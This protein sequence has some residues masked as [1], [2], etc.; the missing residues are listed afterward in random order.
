MEKNML[1][2]KVNTFLEVCKQLNFTKAAKILNLT[3]PAVSQQIK[4]LEDYYQIKLFIY[5][6]NKLSLTKNGEIVK[7]ALLSLK[8]NEIALLNTLKSEKAIIELK[9][10]ATLTVSSFIM[11]KILPVL[12]NNQKYRI[13]M[14]SHNTQEL[15]ALLDNG[16]IDFAIIEG[17][18]D[19]QIYDYK[20]FSVED[21]VFVTANTNPL[22][23]K[24]TTIDKLLKN[25]LIIREN[26]SGSR[27]ILELILKNN[28]LQIQDF[29]CYHE[30][31]NINTIKKLVA[32]NYG[33]SAM[34]KIAVN[35]NDKLSIIN[36]N[37][38]TRDINFIWKKNS[39]FEQSYLQIYTVLKNAYTKN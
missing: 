14:V 23:N 20:L 36:I 21:F 26:G 11:P 24:H 28:S 27:E 30:I 9:F 33:I 7:D 32:T 38:Y 29:N 4:A 25:N 10:G 16:T 22:A 8:H 13:K 31:A 6:N 35:K 5:K 3:Q 12:I 2:Q 1:D 37:D 17:I 18:F 15:L 34:Y 39:L 19:K